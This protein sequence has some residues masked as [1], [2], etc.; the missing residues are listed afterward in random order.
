[1][2]QKGSPKEVT[3]LGIGGVVMQCLRRVD[4]VAYVRFA[5]V[6]DGFSDLAHFK[7]LIHAVEEESVPIL[8]TQEDAT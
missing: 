6:Y 3:S 4:A 8:E 1:M 5:S 7:T 2:I